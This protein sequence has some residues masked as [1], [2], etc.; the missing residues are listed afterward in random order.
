MKLFQRDDML[1]ATVLRTF[2]QK[3]SPMFFKGDLN[4]HATRKSLAGAGALTSEQRKRRVTFCGRG[5]AV[6]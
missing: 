1:K 3:E 4:P 2:L 5:A 6:R